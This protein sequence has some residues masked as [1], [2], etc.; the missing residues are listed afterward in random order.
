MRRD[1]FDIAVSKEAY[2]KLLDAAMQKNISVSQLVES[3]V[4]KKGR[5][6]MN[7]NEKAGLGMMLTSIFITTTAGTVDNAVLR[8]ASMVVALSLFIAGYLT[9]RFAQ[10]E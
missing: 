10:V 1:E 2:D 6:K 9:F 3:Y 4:D 7:S 5:V 8:A